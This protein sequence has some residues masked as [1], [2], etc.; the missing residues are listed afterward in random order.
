MMMRNDYFGQQELDFETAKE[1][2][3]HDKLYNTQKA[4][5]EQFSVKHT[6]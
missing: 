4:M 6:C 5:V 2:I 1:T 3:V